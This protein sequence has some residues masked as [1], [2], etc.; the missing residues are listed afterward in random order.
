MDFN[1]E[2]S[3]EVNQ[4]LIGST[5]GKNCRSN[6]IIFGFVCIFSMIVSKKSSRTCKY[7]QFFGKKLMGAVELVEAAELGKLR[8]SGVGLS[9]IVGFGVMG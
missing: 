9:C 3:D 7:K 6:R 5:G 8:E 2:K 4:M 1:D